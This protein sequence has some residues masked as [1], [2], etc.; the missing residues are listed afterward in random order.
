MEKDV[1]LQLDCQNLAL[2]SEVAKSILH[3][4][5]YQLQLHWIDAQLRGLPSFS[6]GP[7]WRSQVQRGRTLA[8]Q[9][10]QKITGF[11]KFD[12]GYLISL[13]VAKESI[14][15]CLLSCNPLSVLLVMLTTIQ[16]LWP[17]VKPSW[18]H[19]SVLFGAHRRKL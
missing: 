17:S 18:G 4:A 10:R 6:Q 15:G 14:Y 2:A 12:I 19:T 1:F 11:G 8:T 9:V 5:L 7:Q 16:N 3:T 13:V